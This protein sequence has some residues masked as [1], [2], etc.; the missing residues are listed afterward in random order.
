MAD[1]PDNEFLAEEHL[2]NFGKIEA[3]KAQGFRFYA[4]HVAGSVNLFDIRLVLSDVDVAGD[5]LRPVQTL[6]VLMSPELAVLAHAT[7]GRSIENYTKTYGKHRLPDKALAPSPAE[8][9]SNS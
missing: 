4:N 8:S 7:L 1:Q 5:G 6:T 2:V 3:S 9:E